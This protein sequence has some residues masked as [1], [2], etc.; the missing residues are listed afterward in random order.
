[1]SRVLL[2]IVFQFSLREQFRHPKLWQ[3]LQQDAFGGVECDFAVRAARAVH[4][5]QER[6]YF[7]AGLDS[8]LELAGA[9]V[10]LIAEVGETLVNKD[11]E[12]FVDGRRREVG[13]ADR[14]DVRDEVGV[15]LAGSVDNCA[16]PGRSEKL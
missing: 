10:L 3:I 9:E 6:F 1:M 7:G 16:A 2:C 14:E 15:V 11:M 5:V 4:A 12:G 8:L 13:R